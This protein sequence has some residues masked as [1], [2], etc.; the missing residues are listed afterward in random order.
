MSDE[1]KESTEELSDDQLE[2]V[3]GGL[4]KLRG[5]RNVSLGSRFAAKDKGSLIKRGEKFK[6]LEDGKELDVDVV[7]AYNGSVLGGP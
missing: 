4:R 6:I 3:A 1:S 2:Q 7:M 5:K